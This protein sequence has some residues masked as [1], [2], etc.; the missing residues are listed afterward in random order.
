ML[1]DFIF[2]WLFKS[3]ALL[4]VFVGFVGIL[5]LIVFVNPWWALL[6]APWLGL[7]LALQEE[8]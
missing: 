2:T 7:I 1:L 3:L 6:L 5:Y 4:F 8:S